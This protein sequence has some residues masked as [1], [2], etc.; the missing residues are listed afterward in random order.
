M[1]WNDPTAQTKLWVF[2]EGMERDEGIGKNPIKWTS[3]YGSVV[4]SFYDAGTADEE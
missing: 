2:S 1:D 4:A 3:K